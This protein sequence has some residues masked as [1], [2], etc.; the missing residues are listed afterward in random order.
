MSDIKE[1]L[2]YSVPSVSTLSVGKKKVSILRGINGFDLDN[3]L[4]RITGFNGSADAANSDSCSAATI[5]SAY[6]SENGI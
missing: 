6:N 5:S 1:L 2:E 4:D 3:D